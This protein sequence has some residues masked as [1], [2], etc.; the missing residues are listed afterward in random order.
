MAVESEMP[1]YNQEER[2]LLDQLPREDRLHPRSEDRLV[3]ALRAEG[4]FRAR[5]R[6]SWPLQA[7]AAVVLLLIGAW[8]GAKW[9]ERNSLEAML[10][11]EGLGPLERVLLLQRAGSAY[12]QAANAYAS[13]TARAD[14]T[15]VEVASQVLL[16]AAQAVARNGLD[17]GLT[18]QLTQLLK[19]PSPQ[20]VIWF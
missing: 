17:A 15:A 2:R 8:G 13:A 3:G 18:P 12:V 4:F 10:T 6:R 20:T 11:R 19:A 7:V 1:E 5:N 9:T 14:S 16:G